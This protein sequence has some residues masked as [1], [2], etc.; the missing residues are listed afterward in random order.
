MNNKTLFLLLLSLYT[1]TMVIASQNNQEPHSQELT[2][3]DTDDTFLSSILSDTQFT[4]LPFFTQPDN[5]TDAQP[6]DGYASNYQSDEESQLIPYQAY[7][8][9]IEQSNTHHQN[10]G[11]RRTRV[12]SDSDD[13]SDDDSL[14]SHNYISNFNNQRRRTVS[15][16][17]ISQDNIHALHRTYHVYQAHNSSNRNSNH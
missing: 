17:I 11:T 7:L 8:A 13:S 1:T 2:L 14:S 6:N 9:L 15:P 5:Y 10:R 4:P 16:D 3:T 12:V